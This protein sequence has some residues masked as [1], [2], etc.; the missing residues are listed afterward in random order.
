MENCE[1]KIGIFHTYLDIFNGVTILDFDKCEEEIFQKE[2][3]SLI[4]TLLLENRN[5]LWINLSIKEASK[6]AS[7]TKRGFTFFS[8]EENSLRMIKKLKENPIIP[9]PANHTAGVGAVVINSKEEILLIKER[10]RASHYKLPG[11]HID[12]DELISNSLVREVFEETGVEVEFDSIISLGHFYPDQFNKSNLYII[13]R[14]KPLTLEINIRD[15]DEIIDAKW[16]SLDK[17]FAD[18]EIIEYNKE[19]VKNAIYN[20][21]LYIKS[22]D[23]FKNLKRV[24]ELFF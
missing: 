21:G 13:C 24:H 6:I 16:M 22:L 7:F 19:I 11:G 18:E 10:F 5:L 17:F 12:S 1:K 3:D 2:L 14:A 8:C 20:K 9:T 23:S 4:E 15:V